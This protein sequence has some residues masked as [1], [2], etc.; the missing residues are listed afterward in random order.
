MGND[1]PTFSKMERVS[2]R[3]SSHHSVRLYAKVSHSLNKKGSNMSE[4][5]K[6]NNNSA[7]LP[8]ISD[9]IKE[10][11]RKIQFTPSEKILLISR[12]RD[13]TYDKI[14]EVKSAIEAAKQNK[15]DTTFLETQLDMLTKYKD[16]LG[17]QIIK[18][19]EETQG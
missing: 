12:D 16:V 15:E 5:E 2:S 8:S 1:K 9:L 11:G 17:T 3:F 14:I 7:E 13:K 19:V 18:L 6:T 10:I 4:N